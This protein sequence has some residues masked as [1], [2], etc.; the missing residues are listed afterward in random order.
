MR[1]DPGSWGSS[2]P[3]YLVLGFSKGA[4]QADIYANGSFDDVAFG[5]EITRRNLTNILRTD[6][7]LRQ[8]E[9]VDEKIRSTEK[10]FHFGSLVRCSLSRYDEKESE[11]RKRPVYATSGPLITKSFFEIPDVISQ[12]T[13]SFL[14][15]L[16]QSIK[17]V[18]VLGVTDS[19]VR[20][21]RRKMRELH[22]HGFRDINLI[23]YENSRM[24]WVHLTHPSRGNGTLNAWLTRG[25][26][27]T[28]GHKKELAVE[29]LRKRRLCRVGG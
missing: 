2:N 7:L 15:Q 5:G 29:V 10:E 3:T 26:D 19:Y 11:R 27:D 9:T 23:A 25:A 4:T 14:A 17:A 6:G 21:F 20:S 18:I 8:D 24:L 22:P 12:C 1:K 13:N 16:P 28:S